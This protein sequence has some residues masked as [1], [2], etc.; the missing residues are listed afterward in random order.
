MRCYP[1]AGSETG[2]AKL[3]GAIRAPVGRLDL[4]D[5]RRALTDQGRGLHLTDHLDGAVLC[6]GIDELI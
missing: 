5:R 2:R 6:W 1:P 4:I 3:A